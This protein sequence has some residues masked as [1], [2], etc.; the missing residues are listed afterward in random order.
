VPVGEDEVVEVRETIF[1]DD[2]GLYSGSIEGMQKIVDACMLFCGFTGMR[3]NLSK[4]R[5][6]VAGGLNVNGKVLD[7]VQWVLS[8]KRWEAVEGKQAPFELVS[9]EEEWRYLGMIQNG[10]GECDK[11]VS[12]LRDEMN[13]AAEIIKRKRMSLAG[14]IY[15]SNVVLVPRALYRLKYLMPLMNK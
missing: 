12:D 3:A 8:S 15:L 13:D 6:M 10:L 14:A 2:A 11:M 7:G 1:A 9:L 5:W 4:C